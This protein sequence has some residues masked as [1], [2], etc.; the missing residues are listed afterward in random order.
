M[1]PQDDTLHGALTVEETLRFSAAYRLPAGLSARARMLRVERALRLL[2]LG[3]LRHELVGSED[4]RGVS[5]GQRKRVSIGV[6]LVADPRLLFLDEPTSGLDSTAGRALVFALRGIARRGVTAA[7]VVH[8]PSAEA[9][10]L[11]DDLLLLGRGG[12]TAYYGPVEDVRVRWGERALAWKSWGSG[13][14][15]GQT[16]FPLARRFKPALL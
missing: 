8:Q 1:A 4:A 3:E 9:F 15:L 14:R 6:E 10:G 16:S 5:G 13:K 7:A 2:G 12:R 11:F